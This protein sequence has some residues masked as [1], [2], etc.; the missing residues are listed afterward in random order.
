MHEC[1]QVSACVAIVLDCAGTCTLLSSVTGTIDG[2][3]CG[4]GAMKIAG[5]NTTGKSGVVTVS[6]CAGRKTGTMTMFT[7]ATLTTCH[8]N[9]KCTAAAGR[10]LANGLVGGEEEEEGIQYWM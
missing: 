10:L 7:T 6:V 2:G 8:A 1:D 5:P 9:A 4:V 3:V